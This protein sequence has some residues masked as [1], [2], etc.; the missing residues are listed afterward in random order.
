MATCCYHGCV[1]SFS[2]SSPIDKI[3]SR[4]RALSRTRKHN[5]PGIPM[6]P[7]PRRMPCHPFRTKERS[8]QTG[9]R[10]VHHLSLE[11]SSF[12]QRQARPC[13]GCT[14][15]PQVIAVL[16]KAATL[17]NAALAPEQRQTAAAGDIAP[18]FSISG[19]P[20]MQLGQ[21]LGS[22]ANRSSLEQR[23]SHSHDELSLRLCMRDRAISYTANDIPPPPPLPWKTGI[24]TLNSL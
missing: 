1:R 15:T 3:H 17:V 18:H 22:L 9:V 23:S 8:R 13:A 11:S 14:L 21:P 10:H 16:V 24:D 5:E 20:P 6:R 12:S 2:T 4:H 7:R 19:D